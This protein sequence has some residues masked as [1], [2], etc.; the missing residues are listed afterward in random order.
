MLEHTLKPCEEP[1]QLR[2]VAHIISSNLRGNT[3]GDCIK[4]TSP[5]AHMI[6]WR[7]QN[8]VPIEFDLTAR[9][10]P[11]TILTDGLE[12]PETLLRLHFPYNTNLLLRNQVVGH[13][14]LKLYQHHCKKL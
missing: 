2:P 8:R 9:A 6:L 12:G 10:K 14:N 11:R 1:A 13:D 5:A 7:E 3:M 4:I